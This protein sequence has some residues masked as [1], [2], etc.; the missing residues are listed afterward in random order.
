[1][2]GARMTHHVV[3]GTGGIGTTALSAALLGTGVAG[4]GDYDGLT[5]GNAAAAIEESGGMPI[6]GRVTPPAD[7]DEMGPAGRSKPLSGAIED[8]SWGVAVRTEY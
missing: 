1:M 6:T 7:S 3:P 8:V 2:L 5:Y 4:A